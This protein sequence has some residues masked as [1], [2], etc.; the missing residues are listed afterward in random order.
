MRK[1]NSWLFIVCAVVLALMFAGCSTESEPGGSGNGKVEADLSTEPAAIKVNEEVRL[2]TQVTGLKNYEDVEVY[3]EWK[4]PDKSKRELVRVDQSDQN[5][6]SGPTQFTET[7]THEVLVHVVT[8]DLHE[9]IKK[10][11]D[12][13]E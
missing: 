5:V 9:I 10:Q 2:I 13:S 12:V 1:R 11:A 8:P 7:G 6:F 4:N 3:F